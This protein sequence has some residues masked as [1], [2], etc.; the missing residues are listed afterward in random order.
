MWQGKYVR[1]RPLGTFA[2]VDQIEKS[3]QNSKRH[4]DSHSCESVWSSSSTEQR[5]VEHSYRQRK[6]KIDR[7]QVGTDCEG[8]GG[9]QV[10][11]AHKA[12]RKQVYDEYLTL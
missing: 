1:R 3:S 8:G 9:D 4:R 6:I 2:R 7:V 10:V 5:S 11:D 12:R